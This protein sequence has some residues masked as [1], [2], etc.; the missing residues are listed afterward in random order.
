MGKT[1]IQIANFRRL[2][3]VER[4]PLGTGTVIIIELYSI[5]ISL[6]QCK[7]ESKPLSK[8]AIVKIVYI[9]KA[10]G[11]IFTVEDVTHTRVTLCKTLNMSQACFT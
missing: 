2:F 1:C 8:L 10:H 5:I 7:K 11:R 9:T 4:E 6:G 3:T